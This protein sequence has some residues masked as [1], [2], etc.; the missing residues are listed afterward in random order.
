MIDFGLLMELGYKSFYLNV[1]LG[2]IKLKMIIIEWWGK[3][4]LWLYLFSF[5]IKIFVFF[6]FFFYFCG[7]D[8]NFLF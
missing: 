2:C 1:L 3:M 5:G 4:I 7:L 6:G 8:N